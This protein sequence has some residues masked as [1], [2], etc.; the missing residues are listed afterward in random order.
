MRAESYPQSPGTTRCGERANRAFPH[1]CFKIF[2][3]LSVAIT[4]LNFQRP[5]SHTLFFNI[6]FIMTRILSVAITLLHFRRLISHTLFSLHS[7]HHGRDT[8]CR[9]NT[10]AFSA[11]DP[12]Y[13][14]FTNPF[15]NHDADTFCRNSTAA[16]SATDFSCLI[17]TN[18]FPNQD[19]D[20]FCRNRLLKT[21]YLQKKSR[22]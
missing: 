2:K 15:S 11:T 5:I 20:T 18:P 22:L 4:L 16:F 9:N 6:P 21:L 1:P 13:L 8:F 7:F 10:T 12:S 3:I 14:I 19:T 17:F